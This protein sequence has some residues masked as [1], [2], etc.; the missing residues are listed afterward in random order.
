MSTDKTVDTSTL[1][2]TVNREYDYLYTGQNVDIKSFQLKFNTLFF[3]AMP[4][5]LGN[6]KDEVSASG[7]VVPD[8]SSKET[9][10][11]TPTSDLKES[12]LSRSTVRMD[13]KSTQ[14]SPGGIANSGQPNL[15]DPYA[16]LAKNM[17]QAI[18]D[19][20]DQCQAEISIIGDPFYLVTGGMGN[21]RPEKDPETGM[22]GEGE[23]PATTDDVMVLL[24]FRNPVDIDMVTGEAI[25]DQS[26][27]PYSGIFRVIQV[28]HTFN[29]GVFD[30]K[31]KMIRIPAQLVDTNKPVE[32][33]ASLTNSN[34][35]PIND[36]T[37]NP[38]PTPN[39]VKATSDSLAASIAAGLPTPG[40]PGSLS[41]LVSGVTGAV[42]SVG[43]LLSQGVAAAGTALP[44]LSNVSSAIR[45][46]ASGL[47]PVS[48]NINSA[49]AS[50]GQLTA[51]ANAAGVSNAAN[52]AQ[53][54]LAS[55]LG[56]ASSI[57]ASAMSGVAS[58][59]SSAADLVSGVG[60]KISG[61][62]GADLSIASSLGVNVGGLS[63]LSSNL[64]SSL[65]KE[66]TDAVKTI[67]QNV[68]I[69][70]AVSK[71]LILNDI[72]KT[73]LANIPATMPIS[74]APPA[75]PN[76]K[77]LKNILDRG[78]SLANIPGAANIPGVDK[79]LAAS[80]GLT[81]PTGLGLDASSV[82]GQLATVQAG[83]GS[84]TGQIP[85]VEA[86]LNSIS[87]MVPSGLPNVSSVASSVANTFGSVSASAASPLSTLIK[88]VS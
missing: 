16:A 41:Q 37:P 17:H 24:K 83:L 9:L 7:G 46:A 36:A 13:S 73:A 70:A 33:Q 6:A 25:F 26:S 43:S 45:L 44:G 69:N 56:S 22:A 3:Q 5:A 23:A 68:D 62:S 2:S 50:I 30:Q 59:G 87:A 12:S 42:A 72:P 11:T 88:S 80:G 31:L 85:S 28:N 67:P 48:T 21:Y 38:P 1:V 4:A 14:V 64:A 71:G 51:T 20:V 61:I 52:L 49:G 29:D 18:L 74:I 82:A 86:G 32:K 78:G 8:G 19:N 47:S 58:L 65:T 55:G 15:T 40:L 77:D 75:V 54:T 39:T 60:A 63:G 84:I 66:I 53:T 79:L 57:G 35:N 27:V 76:L 81:L 10:T 34:P